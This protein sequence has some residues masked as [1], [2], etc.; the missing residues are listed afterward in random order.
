MDIAFRGVVTK[1]TG[2]GVM[3]ADSPTVSVTEQK[4]S[5]WTKN[6]VLMR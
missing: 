4:E 3:E 2:S 1:V 6:R 5:V